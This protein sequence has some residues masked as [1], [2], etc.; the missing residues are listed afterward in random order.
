MV[1]DAARLSHDL[2][3]QQELKVFGCQDCQYKFLLNKFEW[4]IL[5]DL[6]HCEYTSLIVTESRDVKIG[7][8]TVRR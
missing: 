7:S 8:I 4:S 1:E 6:Y 3:V 5:I 2:L